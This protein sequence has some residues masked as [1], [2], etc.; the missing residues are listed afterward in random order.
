M[1]SPLTSVAVLLA[2]KPPLS[3]PVGFTT[4]ASNTIPELEVPAGEALSYG[5]RLNDPDVMQLAHIAHG[6]YMTL[7]ADAAAAHVRR[8]SSAP[9]PFPT[10]DFERV[11]MELQT[12]AARALH[13]AVVVNSRLPA[14][15]RLCRD[16]FLLADG[17]LFESFLAEAE[18]LL[19]LPP[20]GRTASE[21]SAR[22]AWDA[23]LV[24]ARGAAH[25]DEIAP[26]AGWRWANEHW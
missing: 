23:A 13:H 15:L 22:A 7:V 19:A 1:L 2:P 14:H 8:W 18:G 10:L 6:N 20:R 11:A 24:S 26:S 21:A 16:L 25:A 12:S 3:R 4:T 17:H 5:Q 9:G